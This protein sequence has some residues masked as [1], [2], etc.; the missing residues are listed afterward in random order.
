MPVCGC[1]L[2][3]RRCSIQQTFIY[4]AKQAWFASPTQMANEPTYV[5]GG[6]R[7]GMA[8]SIYYHYG[9]DIGG[10]EGLVDVVAATDGLVVSRRHGRLPG[11]E[12]TPVAPR[13]D[14]V[15]LLDD[16]GWF[17]RYSHLH[18]IAP[19]L[20]LGQRMQMGSPSASSA[21]KAAAAAGRICIS[22]SAAGSPRANGASSTA[23]P[24]CGKPT[25]AS[26]SQN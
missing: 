20:K 16:R 26:G 6:E 14:V 11:Y 2:P 15:Y 7:P 5:D 13:Y 8:G 1:G 12:D 4:P 22:M 19:G 9:L 25:F 17:Y 23:T 18:T 10:A 3:A 24:S 21:R